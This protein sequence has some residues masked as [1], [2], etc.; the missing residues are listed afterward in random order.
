MAKVKTFWRLPVLSLPDSFSFRVRRP[1]ELAY[2][3][4]GWGLE[5]KRGI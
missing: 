2:K 4:R 5:V 1:Y 3:E